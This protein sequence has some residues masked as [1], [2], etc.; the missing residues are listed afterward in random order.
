MPNLYQLMG[1][2]ERYSVL[3]S[4]LFSTFFIVKEGGILSSIFRILRQLGKGSFHS[5]SISETRN[6]K[7]SVVV[8]NTSTARHYQLVEK[9]IIALFERNGIGVCTVEKVQIF[10]FHPA[11]AARA[12]FYLF[13]LIYR[14]KLKGVP[15]GALLPYAPSIIQHYQE[16]ILSTRHLRDQ[17][18]DKQ[19]VVVI[20]ENWMP[21]STLLYTCSRLGIKTIH[22]PHGLT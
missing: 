21:S 17:L 20:N 1:S 5:V 3:Q 7:S 10:E 9:N 12:L 6:K 16:L 19:A 18:S 22:Y 13:W 14:L 8:A 11:I 15:V 4:I 2:G